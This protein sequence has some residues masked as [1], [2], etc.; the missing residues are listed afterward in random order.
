MPKVDE[1]FDNPPMTSLE[2]AHA[3]FAESVG[4]VR[5]Y[6]PTVSPIMAMPLDSRA[7]D[8]TDAATLLNG[9][10]GSYQSPEILVPPLDWRVVERFEAWQMVALGPVG[11]PAPDAV[12][13]GLENATEMLAMARVLRPGPFEEHTVELGTYLGIR[14]KGR[15]VAMAGER[16]QGPGWT[17][18]SA[19]CTA[20]EFRGRGLATRLT[21]AVAAVIEA[22]GQVPVL[23][24]LGGHDAARALYEHIGFTQWKAS[25]ITTV[26]P[27]GP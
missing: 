18:I 25:I 22:R 17:E 4:R 10:I 8:W 23:H 14:H 7:A 26:S 20:E 12:V 21:R 6:L 19:V 11:A 9:D 15:L 24:V 1:S 3:R 16:M 27:P 13:L 5:R 2:G